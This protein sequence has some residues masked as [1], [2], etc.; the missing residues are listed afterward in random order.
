[1]PDTPDKEEELALLVEEYLEE[2]RCGRAPALDSYVAEHPEH[3]E[4]LQDL[5]KGMADM[6][7][8]SVS[9]HSAAVHASARYPES[10]GGYRLLERIGAGGMGT[11]FRALQESLN[12]EVAIKILSPA[13]NADERHCEAFENE[14]RVIA[15]LH[16]TNIVEVF[17]AGQEGDYR[18]YVMSL[19]NGQ[20]IV[21]ASI[22]KAYPGV[23]Y[24]VAVAKVGLQAAQALAY[25]HSC[26][27]LHRDVKPGNLL[28]D[29]DGVLR[30]GD[31]G[32]SF[33]DAKP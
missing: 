31:F 25:A 2:L 6:E 7:A 9:N 16:H 14:S 33:G 18:Y 13:W 11:V 1:M 15:G 29:A 20:G 17:G 23:P 27:V 8:L 5:L 32:F 10:L 4:D 26:G 12:R 30:V 3:A 19:V 21:P 24:E 28:L 22:R